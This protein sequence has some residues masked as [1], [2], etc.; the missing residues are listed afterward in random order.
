MVHE[1]MRKINEAHLK[2]CNAENRTEAQFECGA[3]KEWN[4]AV[5]LIDL[6]G[7]CTCGQVKALQANQNARQ[8]Q[9]WTNAWTNL[10]NACMAQK[11]AGNHEHC[12]RIR[13]KT[14]NSKNIWRTR[15]RSWRS[16]SNFPEKIQSIQK[17]S[18]SI[19]IKSSCNAHQRSIINL[20]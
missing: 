15:W 10:A 14:G 8:M 6:A 3:L 20:T 9:T 2:I 7:Q 17:L 18:T 16:S 4:A 5:S 13:R 12:I 11:F 1:Y 19:L